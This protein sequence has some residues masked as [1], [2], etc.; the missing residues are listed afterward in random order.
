MT[1]YHRRLDRQEQQAE[2]SN[3][4][5][6]CGPDGQPLGCSTMRTTVLEDWGP[7]APGRR[8]LVS[9]LWHRR[10]SDFQLNHVLTEVETGGRPELEG[11]RWLKRTKDLTLRRREGRKQGPWDQKELSA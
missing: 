1:M 6:C 9:R 7:R 2:E 8:Y 10:R 5:D 11:G 4:L 3:D